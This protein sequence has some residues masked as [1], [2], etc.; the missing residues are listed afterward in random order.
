MT[1]GKAAS[2]YSARELMSFDEWRK[3]AYAEVEN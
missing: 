2:L 3:G 1:A